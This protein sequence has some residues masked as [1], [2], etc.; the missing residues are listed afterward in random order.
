M[1]NASMPENQALPSSG[2]L[3]R[4]TLLALITALVLLMTVVMPAEYGIDPSGVGRLLGL[5]EMGE[6]KQQLAHEA[7]ADA[8][9]AAPEDNPPETAS[10]V[11][12]TP[13]PVACIA[14]NSPP[15][16]NS[17]TASAS[18]S[19]EISFKLVPGQAA[20][21]K[22]E[23]KEGAKVRFSWTA[24]GGKLNYDTHGDPYNPP[25][26]FYHGYGKGRFEP[27]DKGILEAAFDGNHGWFWRNRT[28]QE[29][30]LTLTVNGDYLKLQRV[31]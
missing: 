1:Y 22:L 13:E 25:K 19:G 29:V 5:T 16:E 6:I 30:T 7:E 23:M 14:D 20:E 21:V 9:N 31:L 26:G 12:P 28:Q 27:G 18:N 17:K 15:V 2:Q 10:D 8:S 4:S 11:Q 3:V 24:N